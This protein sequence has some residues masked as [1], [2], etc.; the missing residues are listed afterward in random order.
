MVARVLGLK[1]KSV[2]VLDGRACAEMESASNATLGL[3][4]ET[5]IAG[6]SKDMAVAL[7]GPM[8]NRGIA[9]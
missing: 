3:G 8:R 7:A 9:H 4:I 1:V 2:N 5:H 6:I